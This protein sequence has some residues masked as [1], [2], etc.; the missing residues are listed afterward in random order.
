M[1][2]FLLLLLLMFAL[3]SCGGIHYSKV[4]SPKWPLDKGRKPKTILGVDTIKTDKTVTLVNGWNGP[5]LYQLGDVKVYVDLYPWTEQIVERLKVE[6]REKGVKISPSG[7]HTFKVYIC[8][9]EPIRARMNFTKSYTHVYIRIEKANG[10]WTKTYK[11]TGERLL[12]LGGGGRGVG[13]PC[14]SAAILAA[15][16]Y[17]AVEAIIKDNEF[18]EAISISTAY[19]GKTTEGVPEKEKIMQKLEYLKEM[20]A[21]G[22]ITEDE[23]QIKKKEILKAF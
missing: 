21:K 6:L 15:G 11:G 18:K 8:N 23:Y 17:N 22:L 1:K 5:Q 20:R 10:T 3:I 14:Y 12:G 16:A 9:V 13:D 19:V 2:K 4:L 7:T